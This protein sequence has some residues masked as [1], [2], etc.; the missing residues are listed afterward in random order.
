[1]K[2]WIEIYFEYRNI[3]Y[4]EN[5]GQCPNDYFKPFQEVAKT[6][7]SPLRKTPASFLLPLFSNTS[8]TISTPH[9]RLGCPLFKSYKF[10]LGGFTSSFREPFLPRQQRRHSPYQKNKRWRAS[11]KLSRRA[12]IAPLPHELSSTLSTTT[13]NWTM[14]VE[15]YSWEVVKVLTLGSMSRAF[16]NLALR[17]RICLALL[18]KPEIESWKSE[19]AT[20]PTLINRFK[21]THLIEELS[22]NFLYIL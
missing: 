5:N 17:S 21:L 8:H 11:L 12:R 22:F 13:C 16:R 4:D 9:C 18:T 19:I 6:L 1:M 10:L 20:S 2:N 7:S 14:V 3:I 15:W